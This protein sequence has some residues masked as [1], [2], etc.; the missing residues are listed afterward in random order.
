MLDFGIYS[1]SYGKNWVINKGETEKRGWFSDRVGTNTTIQISLTTLSTFR[2]EGQLRSKSLQHCY[3]TS[4]P[5]PIPSL[6]SP[7]PTGFPTVVINPSGFA[8]TLRT[9]LIRHR[10]KAHGFASLGLTSGFSPGGGTSWE[11]KVGCGPAVSAECC[12]AI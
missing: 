4:V 1:N 5:I 2:E 12:K 6:Q 11:G 10:S 3:R 8:R 9:L 7:L